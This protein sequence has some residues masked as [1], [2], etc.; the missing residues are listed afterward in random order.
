MVDAL[1]VMGGPLFQRLIPG[2]PKSWECE[3]LRCYEEMFSEPTRPA[4]GTLWLGQVR[5]RLA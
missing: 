2:W 3:N 4:P 5:V 1:R